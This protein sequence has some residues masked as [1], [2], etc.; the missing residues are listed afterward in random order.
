MR[1][2]ISMMLAGDAYEEAWGMGAVGGL[3]RVVLRYFGE[4]AMLHY[5][6]TK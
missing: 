5:N 3:G 2:F 4:T 1:Q 6:A